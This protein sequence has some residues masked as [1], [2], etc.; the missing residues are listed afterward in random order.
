MAVVDYIGIGKNNAVTRDYLRE[1]T[2]M[3]DR[4]IRKEI[5]QA[6]RDGVI[7][8]NNQ[9]GKGYYISEDLDDIEKQYKQNNSRAMSILVQQ[10]HLR[11]KLKEAGRI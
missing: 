11:S 1:C 5:E 2:A 7:I 8:I 9:D 4:V 3:T 10:K 6:R